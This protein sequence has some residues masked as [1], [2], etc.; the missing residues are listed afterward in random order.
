MNDASSFRPGFGRPPRYSP[1][2][3]QASCRFVTEYAGDMLS[4]H[5]LDTSF[6]Y[7]YASRASERLFGYGA[8]EL[9]GRSVFDFIHP[10]DRVAVTKSAMLLRER[11][12]TITTTYRFLTKRNGY[13]WVESTSR[14][15]S[16]P[17]TGAPM[18]VVASTRSVEARVEAETVQARLLREAHEARAAV[19]ADS[20]ARDAFLA[21]MSHEL[22][23]PLNA[24][25]G[26]V[27]LLQLG[28][29]GPITDAQQAA[30]ARV[31]LARGHLLGLV[32]DILSIERLRIGR[33]DYIIEPVRLTEL[34]CELE[35]MVGP[36]V[37]EKSLDHVM[38]V[39][40]GDIVLADRE[41]LMQVL[42]NLLSNAVKFTPPGGCVMLDCPRRADGTTPDRICHIRVRDTGIGIPLQQQSA[43]FQP[44]VQ[45]GD[46]NRGH[47][48]GSG[49]GLAISR[50]LT[51]GMNGELRVR[52]VEGSGASFTVTLSRPAGG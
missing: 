22:R 3:P 42:I 50:E 16:D 39:S 48:D 2:S 30:L 34:V 4:V 1:D 23:T 29:H 27:Q 43:I 7:L 35:A 18:E 33:V 13:V 52:S 45:L 46:A 40:D 5:D 36:Q 44:F 8:A 15:A 24:I 41:R 38:N 49:L 11:N 51:Q 26:H 17:G 37:A 28:V 21:S 9:I 31:D 19:E 14:F 6:T 20:R 12:D 25:G 47:A 32:N 10:D